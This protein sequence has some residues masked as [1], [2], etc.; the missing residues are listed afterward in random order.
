[1]AVGTCREYGSEVAATL[2]RMFDQLG[3]LEGLVRGKTVAVKLNLT[4]DA[5]DR[6]GYLPAEITH[7]VHPQV[8]GATVQLL[9]QAGARRI[10]IVESPTASSV[11]TIQ[12]FIAPANWKPGDFISAASVVELDA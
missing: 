2:A 6:L 4:G 10:R 11:R 7:W 8:V 5:T 12:E 9:G 1:M 3:G